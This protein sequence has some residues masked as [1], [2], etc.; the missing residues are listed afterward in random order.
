M[1]TGS[2]LKPISLIERI[3]RLIYPAKCMVCDLILM[4]DSPAFLCDPCKKGLKRYG[5]G[6]C[7]IAELTE[8]DGLFAAFNYLDGIETA[9]HAFKFK[10][11]PKLSETISRLLYEELNKHGNTPDFDYIV[12]VPMHPRKKR[13]RGYNQS[14]LIAKQLGRYL[15][16]EVRTDILRK[17][18]YT[19]S[20]SRLKRRDRIYNLEGAFSVSPDAFIEGKRILLVDDVLTTGT[21]IN[22][23]AKILRERGVFFIYGIVIAIAEK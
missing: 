11:Q 14:E 9:I 20:Q 12:P 10:N 21:T 7:R 16:K 3:L 8:I 22:N 4:E 23:C 18:R 15:N 2:S 5:R 6:F 17:I 19:R 13:Q 1:K